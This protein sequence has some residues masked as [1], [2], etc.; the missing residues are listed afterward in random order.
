MR[1]GWIVLARFISVLFELCSED[2]EVLSSCIQD[3][4]RDVVNRVARVPPHPKVAGLDEN[5]HELFPGSGNVLSV[6]REGVDV[7]M[8]QREEFISLSDVVLP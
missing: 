8:R 5:L 1:S 7:S 4:H 2:T 3:G 6:V